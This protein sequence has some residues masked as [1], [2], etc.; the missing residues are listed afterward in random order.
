M[1]KVFKILSLFFWIVVIA[2]IVARHPEHARIRVPG[3]QGDLSFPLY[4]L[5]FL[6]FLCGIGW[7]SLLYAKTI[8]VLKSRLRKAEKALA[9]YVSAEPTA[10]GTSAGANYLGAN[11]PDN[12]LI[13]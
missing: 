2:Y 13:D 12:I 1:L 10:S 6:S 11:S 9:N 3:L 4:M 7:A 8:W 5:I